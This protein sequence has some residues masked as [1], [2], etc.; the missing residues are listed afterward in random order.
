MRTSCICLAIGASG[1]SGKKEG[2]LYHLFLEAPA[3]TSTVLCPVHNQTPV[4][5]KWMA[6]GSSE[7]Q[8]FL[9]FTGN[10]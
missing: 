9:A 10:C 3:E 7:G 2:V 6:S 4:N 5:R 8:T 1:N